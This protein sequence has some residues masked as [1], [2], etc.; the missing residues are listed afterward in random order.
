M[1]KELF[2]SKPIH[3]LCCQHIFA[4]SSVEC[5]QCKYKDSYFFLRFLL[6]LMLAKKYADPIC[7]RT[8]DICLYRRLPN[9]SFDFFS[10]LSPPSFHCLPYVRMCCT[11][12]LANLNILE[13]DFTFIQ[14]LLAHFY[15]ILYVRIIKLL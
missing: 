13:Y 2:I 7:V 5:S 9:S 8:I 1:K 4:L 3:M 12:M 6:L 15:S 10:L 14:S 11:K